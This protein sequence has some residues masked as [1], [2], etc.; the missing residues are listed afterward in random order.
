[1]ILVPAG[2]AAMTLEFDERIDPAISARAAGVASA[3][4]AEQ[5]TGIRDVVPTYRSV[6]V[7]FDP[8]QTDQQKLT[9]TLQ[10]LA[11]SV[12]TREPPRRSAIAIP[13]CYG[14]DCGP[15]LA[16]VAAFAGLSERDVVEI[17]SAATYRVLMLGFMP[18]FAYMGI[19]DPRIAAPRLETPRPRVAR[20]SVGIAKEQTGIYP[21]DTPG[22]WQLIGRTPAR[23]FDLTRA[24]P[25]LLHSGDEVQFVPI[26]REEFERALSEAEG[27][28]EGRR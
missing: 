8:L 27:R 12:E 3:V 20:G 9:A 7:Y 4:L 2:D 13:V 17:H 21:R 25:F 6:T 5:L 26:A 18:G 28:V 22:G 11:D 24:D 1:M 14:G 23:T 15:D 16:K 19:V 10:R